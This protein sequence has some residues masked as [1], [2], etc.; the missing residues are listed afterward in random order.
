MVLYWIGVAPSL[1]TAIQ[2][3]TR[4]L[5]NVNNQ[6][7]Y[8]KW[9]TLRLYDFVSFHPRL[10]ESI[11]KNSVWILFYATKAS[12]R[13]RCISSKVWKIKWLKWAHFIGFPNHLYFDFWSFSFYWWK[14]FLPTKLKYYFPVN[15]SNILKFVTI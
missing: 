7:E 9:K 3:V 14:Q 13:R 10:W 11:I 12:R 8:N 4:G 5:V 2:W 1:M 6:I 15:L